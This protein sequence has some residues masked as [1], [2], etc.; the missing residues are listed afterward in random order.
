[1]S[2]DVENNDGG[3]ILGCHFSAMVGQHHCAND[4]GGLWVPTTFGLDYG[5]SRH[6]TLD[7]E[8]QHD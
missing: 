1:M 6:V 4:S 8:L 5:S 7:E 3:I 2:C